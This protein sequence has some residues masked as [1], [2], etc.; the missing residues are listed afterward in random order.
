MDE[1]QGK[2]ALITGAG[3]GIGRAAA[4]AL[5]KAGARIAANDITPV[6]LDETAAQIESAGGQ[7]STYV[8]DISKRLPVETMVQQVLEDFGRIDILVVCSGVAPRASVLDMD[9]WDWD[10]TLSVNLSGPFF[11]IQ[12]VGRIMQTQGSGVIVVLASAAGRAGGLKDRAGFIASK[13]G[14]I[15]LVREAAAEFATFNVRVNAVCPGIIET[16]GTPLRPPGGGTAALEALASDVPLARAGAPEEA[17]D[18]IL[19]L[20]SERSSYITG[21][22]VHVD[23]GM[24]MV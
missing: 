23:G 10:R 19:F 6:N 7:V 5:A 24:V 8:V 1:F 12:Q 21:Q 22:A 13:M 14:L 18:L 9:E 3:R 11:A 17:A 15:G 2:V 16:P 20:C 4:I